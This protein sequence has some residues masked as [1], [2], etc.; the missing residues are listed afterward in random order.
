MRRIACALSSEF[1]ECHQR[2]S[3]HRRP[4]EVDKPGVGR[5][6]ADPAVELVVESLVCGTEDTSR[7]N[8][9]DG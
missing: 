4:L 1:V 7:Q 5:N 9:L 8:N 3:G 6:R 2:R